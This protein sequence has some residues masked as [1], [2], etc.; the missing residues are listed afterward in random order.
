M[1]LEII[2]YDAPLGAE[3]QYI[4]KIEDL[5]HYVKTLSESKVGGFKDQYEMLG[6]SPQKPCNSGLKPDNKPKNRYPDLLPYD[7]SR[8]ILQKYKNDPSSDYINASYVDGYKKG[9]RYICT[10]GPL[11]KT[12][13]DFWRM[14]WQEDVNAIVMT[15]NIIE[16]GKKKCEKYWPDKV[17]KV[18]DLIITFLNEVVFID[19]TIRNFKIVKM[20]VSGHRVVRQYQYTAWPDHGVP[21]YP[22]ALIEMMQNVKDFQKEQQ[23]AT[24]WVL[25]CSAGVGRSGTMMVLDSALEMSL[26]EGKV[27]VLGILYKMRQQRLNLIETVDQYTFVYRALVEYHFGDISYKPANEMVLYFNKLRHFDSGKKKTGLE[28]QFEKLRQLETPFFQQKCLA[29]LTPNNKNKNRDPYIL[30]PDDGRPVLKTSP[31]SNYINAVY[32]YDYGVQNRFVVTQFPLPNTV[33][34][35]WQLLWDTE[36]STIVVLNEI[37]N[38]DESCPTFWPQSGSMQQGNIK[39]QHLASEAEYF[40]G[41]LVRKFCVKNPKGKRRTIKTFH[42]H[43]WRREDFVPPQVDTIVQLI[44]KVE[45]WTRKSGPA[46]IL[47]TCYDGCRAS[48]FYCAASYLAAQIHDTLQADVIQAVRTVRLHRPTF[49][50]TV[51]RQIVLKIDFCFR[52]SNG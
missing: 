23:K 29:A 5:E 31:P 49:I 44:A 15:A 37:S 14:I 43:G 36:S 24:P 45:K 35:F 38:K 46:P 25:H 33:P 4:V 30:P 13:G 3:R 11:D 20:G 28:I 50:P 21:T 32:A 17:L 2:N 22:L 47:V 10:Q 34:D 51:V 27:D 42:L 26:A 41:V 16:H 52:E 12:V 9:T 6:S 40:G 39:I 8:V 1:T 48:G 18:A 7:D 19:Y